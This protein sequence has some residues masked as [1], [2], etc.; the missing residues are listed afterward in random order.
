M[1]LFALT[2]WIPEQIYFPEDP[3]NIQDFETPPDRAWK[4]LLSASSFGDCLITVAC[5]TLSDEEANQVGLVTGHAYAVL[6]VVESKNGEKL[7]Q[8]KNPWANKVRLSQ[9]LISKNFFKFFPS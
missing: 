9:T 8:V 7:L 4:R 6:K 1:D 3:S 2:G 5:D